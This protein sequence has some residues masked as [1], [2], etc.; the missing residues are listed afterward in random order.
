MGGCC[1]VPRRRID[2]FGSS[3]R[4]GR[5][6]VHSVSACRRRPP[7]A[8]CRVP[9]GKR[10][11]PAGAGSADRRAEF[12]QYPV[13]AGRG[14]RQA[15]RN[16]NAGARRIGTRFS[17][18]GRRNVQGVHEV[19][20]TTATH[21]LPARHIRRSTIVRFGP[22]RLGHSAST[23]FSFAE[24]RSRFIA[25]A[26][27]YRVLLAADAVSTIEKSGTGIEKNGTGIQRGGCS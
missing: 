10:G 8:E 27:H 15:G 7:D 20:T 1:R 19:I 12:G 23:S 22:P 13:P 3:S 5:G 24:N 25:F 4:R 14:P 9:G 2:G 17:G 18:S 6:A 11:C 16:G 26:H 21:L